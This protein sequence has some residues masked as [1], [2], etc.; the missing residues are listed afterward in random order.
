MHLLGRRDRAFPGP[1]REASKAA[2]LLGAVGSLGMMLRVGHRNNSALL[3]ILFTVWVL[4]PFVGL[5][6][7]DRVSPRW[8]VPTRAALYALACAI[9][10]GSLVVYSVVALGPPRSQP[11]AAF[12]VVP[13][14]SWLVLLTVLAIAT[15]TAGR[16]SK[17]KGDAATPGSERRPK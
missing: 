9:S 7:T 2:A 6:L 11:A 15:R 13:V 10:V 14:A 8:S 5:V 1:L 17:V 3:L 4:S 16:R 12:L